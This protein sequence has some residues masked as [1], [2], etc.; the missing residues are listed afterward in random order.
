MQKLVSPYDWSITRLFSDS[1]TALIKYGSMG[2]CGADK[3]SLVK[4]AGEDFAEVIAHLPPPRGE[5]YVHVIAL[6]SLDAYG[7]NRKGDAFPEDVCLRYGKTFEKHARWYRNHRH[8]DPER[9][10][11]V[12]KYSSYNKKMRRIDLVVALNA[13]KEAADRNGGLI[14]DKELD[15]LYSGE[16]LPVSMAC[17]VSYDI[18]SGCGNRARFRREYCTAD[19]CVKYGGCQTNLGKVFEDGHIL[20]VINPD[21]VFFDISYVTVPADR[22]AYTMGLLRMPSNTAPVK[23]SSA[24]TDLYKDPETCYPS[25]MIETIG[26]DRFSVARTRLLDKLVQIERSYTGVKTGS[27]PADVDIPLTSSGW[28]LAAAA[29]RK[30]CILPPQLFRRYLLP[31]TRPDLKKVASFPAADIFSLL[32]SSPDIDAE[33]EFSPYLTGISSSSPLYSDGINAVQDY[34]LYWSMAPDARNARMKARLFKSASAVPVSGT[35]DIWEL[36]S[37]QRDAMKEYALYQLDS[38]LLSG[39]DDSTLKTLVAMNAGEMSHLT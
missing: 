23:K 37:E 25:W 31:Q 10:Y 8:N 18:C 35:L 34:Y 4:R 33:L 22:I 16:S 21:P 29:A 36:S 27:Y 17:R 12:V 19:K 11:G 1:P 39:Y 38:L 15:L 24:I 2:V 14:A 13:T 3:G 7:P 6:G 5:E 26:K 9:S 32:R 20:H 28:D 30:S